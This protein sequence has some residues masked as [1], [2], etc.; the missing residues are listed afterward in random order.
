MI[1]NQV[2]LPP[3]IRVLMEQLPREKGRGRVAWS[4]LSRDPER[5][6][7][8][9][10]T[11]S[12]DLLSHGFRLNHQQLK[13]T[14]LSSLINAVAR[15]YP[16]GFSGLK[17]ELGVSVTFTL[18]DW[19]DLFKDDP[20]KAK[21]TMEEE[22]RR[23]LEEHGNL[24]T[25]TLRKVRN[26][27]FVDAAT[28]LY[29]GAFSGLKQQLGVQLSVHPPGYW[30]P[31]RIKE[32]AQKVVDKEGELSTRWLISH[33]MS[34]LSS[35]ITKRYPGKWRQLRKDLG[36]KQKNRPVGY[37]TVENIAKE[38]Q[39]FKTAEGGL[40]LA[41][42]RKANLG[43]YS[44]I[45]KYYPGGMKLLRRD[46]GYVIVRKD[47]YWNAER[48]RSEA[49]LYLQGGGRLVA[50]VLSRNGRGDLLGAI[51]SKYPGGLVQLRVDL[52]VDPPRRPNGYWTP[53]QIEIEAANF[54]S[55]FGKITHKLMKKNGRADL[56]TAITEKYPGGTQALKEK[57]G[58]KGEPLAISPDE[59][60][61]ELDKLLEG[62]V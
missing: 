4:V 48:I 22:A 23:L 54:F 40:D 29:P 39:E 2:E 27:R 38:M 17:S 45:G 36:L 1:E 58:I 50:K 20:D 26:N 52:S 10:E 6:R 31:E 62:L 30:T 56:A 57:L 5:F 12:N 9:V 42:M 44:A 61:L 43:L 34:G 37:W 25:V 14:G 7:K 51:Y 8:T 15:Y 21:K 24:K 3:S 19:R 11:I 28:R 33:G 18:R 59:A 32:E 47:G 53:L 46:M 49:E 41:H 60:T 13:K 55:E 35:V 16:G